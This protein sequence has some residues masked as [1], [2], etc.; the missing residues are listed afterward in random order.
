[1][2]KRSL[3]LRKLNQASI[4]IG[5]VTNKR[6]FQDTIMLSPQE[7]I[8]LIELYVQHQASD[9]KWRHI[10]NVRLHIKLIHELSNLQGMNF[11]PSRLTECRE[12][13]QN[14]RRRDETLRAS[15]F[16]SLMAIIKRATDF[17]GATSVASNEPKAKDMPSLRLQSKEKPFLA[18][19]TT[20]TSSSLPSTQPNNNSNDNAGAGITLFTSNRRVR[21][22]RQLLQRP[23]K[24]RKICGLSDD[25]SFVIKGEVTD[26]NGSKIESYWDEGSEIP[27]EVDSV[28]VVRVDGTKEG[29]QDITATLKEFE[30]P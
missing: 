29:E 25:T 10:M 12:Y 20:T 27:R 13:I 7:E 18:T 15:T 1:M 2:R 8:L 28:H 19:T 4:V 3:N 14:W 26:T 5:R 30:Y 24:L 11:G 22:G 6:V 23:T 17:I 9:D 16:D 21:V